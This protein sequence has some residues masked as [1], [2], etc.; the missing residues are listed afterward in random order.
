MVATVED[1]RL[2]ALRPDKDHPLS[3]GFACQKGIA[4]TEIVN[5]PD[6]VTI[7]LRRRP[8]GGFDE[9]S[10]DEAMTDIATRLSA[11]HE[12]HGAGSIGWYVGNPGAFSYDHI[13]AVALFLTG[14]GRR[15][16]LYTASSQDSHPRLMASQLLYGY[17]LSV[18]FPDLSR[19]EL[20][21]VMGANPVVS[22]GSLIAAP[23]MRERMHDIVK[24]GG[25]VLV[26]DPRRTETA[27]QF[28]WLGIR[29][30]GDALL[31]L[32]LLQVMFAEDLVGR[33]AVAAKAEGVGWL[34]EQSAPF[35]P[36]RTESVTGIPA[37]TGRALAR[38]LVRTPRAA[39]YGRLGTCSG[40]S[41]TL[42]TYLLD[43]VNLVAG[44]L[45][46]PGGAVFG[47]LGI[48]GEPWVVTA[49]GALMRRGYRRN[50][51]RIGGFGNVVRSEPATLMAQEI[52]EPGEGQIR[53]LFVSAGNPV[54]S[55]PNGPALSDA[56]KKL[57]LSV[58]LDFY[59]T[60]TTAQCDY[61]LPT[62]T[63]YEREDFPLLSQT[64]LIKP[65]RQATTAVIPPRGQARTEWDII[66]DLMQRMS[67]RT[68]MFTILSGLRSAARLAGR[69]LSLR[70]LVDVI[71]RFGPGGDVGGLRRGGLSFDSLNSDHPHGKVL[72]EEIATGVLAKVVS[73]R[74][75]RIKLKH[76]EIGVDI[77]ALGRRQ[78]PDTFPLRLIGMRDSRSE[79]SWMHN[80]PLL[81]RGERGPKAMMNVA[82]AAQRG[83]VEGDD[84]AVRSPFGKIAL[85]VA[86][87]EDIVIGTVAI[88]HGW[89]H[90][91]GGWRLANRAGGANV[92]ELTSSGA[93]DVESLSGMAW[94]TGVPIEVERT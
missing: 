13:P 23:R 40:R 51:T 67:G 75:R 41:G 62:T 69:R 70:P 79:N 88:P 74:D 59:V 35:T 87:T 1:G 18:P 71:I 2:V 16:H 60:E 21:V 84:V 4:F 56:M 92:N 33:P 53:A 91:G 65:F 11:I 80:A 68:R 78:D 89:G 76:N 52:E 42:T 77:T 28:D 19:T 48:P 86:L 47:S 57:E 81:M 49:L 26:I 12:Q 36:E 72:S 38:D 29:P 43:A 17:P 10:W 15:S 93:A 27:A 9:V 82:D 63:M 66:D 14:L 22:H 94:L 30:D 44:N 85:P 45:D 31:L 58:A 64:F 8:D 3:A 25:R 6:R 83:I 32:S 5:D 24:R 90:R 39:L 46:V 37:E 73:Y 7:P 50:R 55:V 20:L 61:I 34:A 54:L